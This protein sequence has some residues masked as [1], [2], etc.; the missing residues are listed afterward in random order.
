MFQRYSLQLRHYPDTQLKDD[1]QK[2]S[3]YT[4]VTIEA[5]D[6]CPRY[7]ARLIED[8]TIGPSPAWLQDRIRSVGMRP[9]NNV[10]DITNFVMMEL[11]QPLHAF[12]FDML[13]E[14]RIV[15]RRAREGEKFVSLDNKERVLDSEMLMICDGAKPVG[16][17][18]VM[19]GLNSEVEASTR[20]VL[21]ESACFNPVSIR[22]T[23]KRLNLNSEASHRFERGV[24]PQGTV[25]ALNR[26]A[27]LIAELGQGTLVA[28]HIDVHPGARDIASIRLNVNRTNRLLGTTLGAEEMKRLLENIEIKSEIEC[29][30]QKVDEF[31]GG[32]VRQ[33]RDILLKSDD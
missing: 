6:L 28:G 23:A 24:D 10:V 22:R 20:R 19:G 4:S 7:T 29:S 32:I 33:F 16:I 27:K 21:L 15:V 18:G 26:A 3:E 11:G 30:G 13:E 2:I 5:P 1:G 14:H 31:L 9:I 25:A 12:D 8:V 17:G